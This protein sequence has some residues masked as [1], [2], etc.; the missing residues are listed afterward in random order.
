MLVLGASE[1]VD[2]ACGWVDDRSGGDSVFWFDNVAAQI[3]GGDDRFAGAEEVRIPERGGGA[4]VGIVGV[5]GIVLGG[6]EEEVVAAFAGNLDVS[7]QKRLG[8]DVA[9][10][11]EGEELA[12]L[13]GVD[14]TRGEG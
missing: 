14:V 8:V 13:L 9:I 1:K 5:D 10:D 3:P 6:D 11:L 4:A 7:D 12:K 2:G